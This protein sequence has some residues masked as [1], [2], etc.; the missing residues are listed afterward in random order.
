MVTEV[1][2]KSLRR[3][4]VEKVELKGFLFLK[5]IFEEIIQ[6]ELYDN[7][8]HYDQERKSFGRSQTIGRRSFQ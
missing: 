1:D 3:S 7:D 8:L 2:R 4:F 5:N 6:D